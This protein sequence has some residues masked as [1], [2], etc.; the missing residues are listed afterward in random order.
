MQE[1]FTLYSKCTHTDIYEYVLKLSFLKLYIW[2][3][4]VLRVYNQ[5]K[6]Q[7]MYSL[8]A[9]GYNSVRAYDFNLLE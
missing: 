7:L 3:N 8:I 1:N 5:Y 2:I 4:L 6:L 9:R